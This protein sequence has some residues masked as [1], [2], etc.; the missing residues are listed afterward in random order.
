[1][2]SIQNPVTVM[3]RSMI[4][5]CIIIIAAFSRV[6]AQDLKARPLQKLIDCPSAGGPEPRSFDFELRTFP[7]NGVLLG[8]NIGLF[9]RFALGVSYGGTD[10]IGYDA[11]LWNPQPGVSIAYR[12]IDESVALPG[13]AVGFNNQGYGRW[14]DDAGRYQ[15]QPKGFYAVTGKNFLVWGLGEM[16]LHFGV[17][18]NPTEASNPGVDLFAA[19]NYLMTEQLGFIVEYS[20]ALDDYHSDEAFGRGRGYM[21]AGVRWSFGQRF[22]I[23]LHFKDLLVNQKGSVR[24]GSRVG[25]EIR[26]S[27]IE[28]L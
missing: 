8:F 20:P 13:L 5:S 22:A 12:L 14:D 16:G 23:D 27:Y 2:K 24:L 15:Y 21:H 25:R 9:K 10:V 4:L 28:H 7:P 18:Y 26:I 17:N 6:S 3:L 1:M 19:L 11:P